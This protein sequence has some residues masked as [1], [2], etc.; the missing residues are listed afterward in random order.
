MTLRAY[1]S[2]GLR[3]NTRNDNIELDIQE[4]ALMDYSD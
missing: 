4:I 3:V 2:G 1:R